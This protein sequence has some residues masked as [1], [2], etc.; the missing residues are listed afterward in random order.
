[1][2]ATLLYGLEAARAMLATT[3]QG[4]R[5]FRAAHGRAPR[6][7]LVSGGANRA[8]RAYAARIDAFAQTAGVETCAVDLPAD[9]SAAQV[10]AAIAALNDDDAVDGILP[11]APLSAQVTL[12]QV[13]AWLSPARDVDGLTPHHA[14]LLA[15]GLPGLYPCTAQ[16]AVRIAGDAVGALRGRTATVVGASATV[17]WP[18]AT[19]LVRR[20]VTVTVAHADTADLPAA[21]RHADLLFVAV[22]RA[23]LIDARHV[24]PGAT[25]IDIGVNVIPEAAG[26]VRIVGDVDLAAV[27]PVARAVT[28]VPDGVGPLTT[29]FLIDNTLRAANAR[30]PV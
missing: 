19:M 10:A 27:A 7:A 17:G 30:L 11:L 23:G 22:G 4:T 8:A 25:V 26:A 15:A 29:A 28:A 3:A 6:L 20:G 14:G 24:A 5:T 9:A 16:A 1:M 18:L 2:T 21:C 12:A 13:A